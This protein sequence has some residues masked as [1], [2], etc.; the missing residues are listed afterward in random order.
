MLF[1]DDFFLTKIFSLLLLKE[2]EIFPNK[3]TS[4]SLSSCED[5]EEDLWE[6]LT[7][8]FDEE[9]ENDLKRHNEILILAKNLNYY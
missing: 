8:E 1:F 4:S 5:E 2:G 9:V 3:L 6:K 7:E